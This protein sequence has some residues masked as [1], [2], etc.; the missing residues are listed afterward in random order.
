MFIKQ[1]LTISLL[2]SLAVIA[3]SEDAAK[4]AYVAPVP[5]GDYVFFETFDQDS[6]G[7]KWLKSNAKKDGVED[8]IAKYD[9]QWLVESSTDSV[10]D[11]DK[12]LVLKSKA[13]HHAISSKLL[14]TFQ[15]TDGKSL[16]VQYEV[17]FQT[18]LECGGAYVKLL[19]DDA[20]LNL[21]KFFDK[22]SFSVMFGPDKCG[23]DNKFHF[24]IRYKNPVTGTFEEKHAKKPDFPSNVF[25]DGNSHLYTLIVNPDNTYKM[26][27]DLNEVSAGSLLTDMTPS[28]VP[29]KE[30][31]DPEDKKPE[32]WDEREQIQDINAVKPDDWDE[33]EPE[34]VVD[35]EAT[36]PEGWLVDEPDMIPDPEAVRP[37][38]W[39][40]DTDGEWEAPKVEN[41]KCKEGPGCGKWEP[42]MISNPKYKGK[43]RLPMIP[44]PSYQGLWEP[45]KIPNPEYFEETNPFQSLTPFSALGLELWSMTENIY[46][47]NFLITNDEQVARQLAKDS[48]SIRH[49]LELVQKSKS[50]EAKPEAEAS[51]APE[52]GESETA[53]DAEDETEAE[54]SGHMNDEL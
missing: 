10:L 49:E 52:S 18:P 51:E 13:K 11:G 5:T 15:F 45:R 1:Y 33:N 53:A 24:I 30:I 25:S 46:F 38:D 6:I 12:G 39:D 34:K 26:L 2:V 31:V 21:D 41:P 42:P 32:S 4:Q 9:G 23:S 43:W 29:P 35:T 19:S 48:W 20:S 27:I 47:D 36:M 40:N 8:T 7:T 16:V 44:N 17:K 28:I 3:Q 50:A 14:S 54:E 22:T 37:D